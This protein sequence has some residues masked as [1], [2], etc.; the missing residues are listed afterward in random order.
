MLRKIWLK[1]FSC[2]IY[3]WICIKC[4][5]SGR[6]EMENGKFLWKLCF[7][8]FVY[9]FNGPEVLLLILSRPP[10]R[11]LLNSNFKPQTIDPR[12]IRFESSRS[13]KHKHFNDRQR[14]S[15]S[16]LITISFPLFVH[17]QKKILKQTKMSAHRQ[18]SGGMAI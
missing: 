11:S 8:P 5:F 16:R 6:W 3:I 9:S 4:W 10:L 14:F 17:T 13:L 15:K 7:R 12:L 1:Y 2:S 18:S